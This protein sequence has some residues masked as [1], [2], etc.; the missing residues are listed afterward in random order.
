MILSS[1]L[2]FGILSSS[3]LLFQLFDTLWGLFLMALVPRC[4]EG[5]FQVRR[6]KVIPRRPH[7]KA[8]LL[9]ECPYC[10]G[11]LVTE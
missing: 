3:Q 4:V 6:L 5:R 7:A 8:Q 2:E 10:T 9:S 1:F 11:K